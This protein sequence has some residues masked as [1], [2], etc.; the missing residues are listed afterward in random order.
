[1][2]KWALEQPADAV[3]DQ[4]RL[5]SLALLRKILAQNDVSTLSELVPVVLKQLLKVT[6]ME[7]VVECLHT[8]TEIGVKIQ[9]ATTIPAKTWSVEILKVSATLKNHQKRIV[10]KFARTCINTWAC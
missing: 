7:I 6:N 8:L 3:N 4:V 2:A 1:M 5:K 9:E 10:R